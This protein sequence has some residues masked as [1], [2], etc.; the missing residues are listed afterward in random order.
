MR[1]PVRPAPTISSSLARA[2]FNMQ[3]HKS[4]HRRPNNIEG[5][6]LITHTQELSSILQS[7]IKLHD[8]RSIIIAIY[9]TCILKISD[10]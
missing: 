9:T 8:D 2:I 5:V 4:C 6:G 10:R 7:F 3:Y 1:D